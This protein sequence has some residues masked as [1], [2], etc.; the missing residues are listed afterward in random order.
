MVCIVLSAVSS[1]V[2]SRFFLFLFSFLVVVL[3][4]VAFSGGG[5]GGGGGGGVDPFYF[6]LRVLLTFALCVY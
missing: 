4:L 5:G 6:L 1:C 3:L 2:F